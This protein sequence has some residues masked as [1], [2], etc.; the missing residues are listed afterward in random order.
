MKFLRFS[1]IYNLVSIILIIN[2]V[3]FKIFFN[4]IVILLK[5][6]VKLW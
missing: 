6:I 1:K 3:V 5:F 4:K 2:N